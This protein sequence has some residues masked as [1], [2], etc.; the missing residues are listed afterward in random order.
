MDGHG[1]YALFAFTIALG[2][3]VRMLLARGS[4]AREAGGPAHPLGLR[5][6]RA[7]AGAP[8]IYLA[9][10]PGE[11]DQASLLVQCLCL[12]VFCR[13]LVKT[14]GARGAGCSATH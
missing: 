9:G 13:V 11:V 1:Q 8:G 5:G 3:S 7:A 14:A 2:Q 6:A 12:L 10:R 4:N